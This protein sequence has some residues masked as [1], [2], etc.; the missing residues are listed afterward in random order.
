MPGRAALYTLCRPGDPHVSTQLVRLR[1]W[2]RDRAWLVCGEFTDELEAAPRRSDDDPPGLAAALDLIRSGAANV[3]GLYSVEPFA[4]D[5]LELLRFARRVQSCGAALATLE[6][7][8]LD[9]TTG[10][11][12]AELLEWLAS[13][14]GELWRQRTTSA[15]ER[16]QHA[17][18]Q[19]GRPRCL[20]PDLDVVRRLRSRGFGERRLVKRL[21]CSAWAAR[22]ALEI[23]DS[24][25]V[26]ARTPS[27]PPVTPRRRRAVSYETTAP[28]SRNVRK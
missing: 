18:G 1:R 21:G 6:A 10:G 25:R 20:L 23:I 9:L 28:A 5:G 14:E 17:G 12:L 24:E 4:H 3:L 27:A 19:L 16:F 11:P 2:A 22:L 7:P 13:L 26:E 8:R 15:I